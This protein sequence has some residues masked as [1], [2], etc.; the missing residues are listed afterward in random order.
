M[1]A[2]VTNIF[3]STTPPEVKIT[4]GDD[5]VSFN[6]SYY[7]R[8]MFTNGFDIFEQINSYWDSLP[9]VKQN[10]IFECYKNLAS[11]FDSFMSKQ[12][13]IDELNAWS[14]ALLNHHDFDSLR[15]WLFFSSNINIP[16]VFAENFVYD[17][18]KQNSIEQTYLKRK[19]GAGRRKDYN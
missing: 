8:N 4:H 19:Q 6:V 18:D 5:A 1:R 15:N 16:N 7:G 3:L 9:V 14:I 2:E 12:N 13:M 11:I 10:L 17:I